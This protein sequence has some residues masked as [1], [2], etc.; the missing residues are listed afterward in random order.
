MNTLRIVALG[1]L[2]AA[3]ALVAVITMNWRDEA[4]KKEGLR[5]LREMT[6]ESLIA[7]CGQPSSDIDPFAPHA[8][9]LI[10]ATT[11][12]GERYAG[13]YTTF[14]RS[15]EYRGAKFPYWVKLEFTRDI[16]DRRQPTP[17]RL[18]HFASPSVGVSPSDDNAYIAIPEFRCMAQPVE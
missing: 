1:L 2:G 10:E 15:I 9:E 7:S 12:S 14:T 4:Q 11:K 8:K 5:I 18:T 6:P 16:D 17:W 13:P 3:A